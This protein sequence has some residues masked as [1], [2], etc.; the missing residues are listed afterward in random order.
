MVLPTQGGV[1]VLFFLPHS[2]RAR[3]VTDIWSQSGV[4]LGYTKALARQSSPA[5]TEKVYIQAEKL[6][7]P[8]KY[9]YDYA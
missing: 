3:A 9:T 4:N 8:L 1:S 6:E 7:H 5:V 2:L